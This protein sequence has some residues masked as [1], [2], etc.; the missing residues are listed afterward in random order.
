MTDNFADFPL[1]V[2]IRVTQNGNAPLAPYPFAAFGSFRTSH[3]SGCA[4]ISL[5]SKSQ[6]SSM[7]C[8]NQNLFGQKKQ[9]I[10]LSH[11]A[12]ILVKECQFTRSDNESDESMHLLVLP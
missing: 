3:A 1:A 12:T 6:E 8:S 10:A 4:S 5:S 9:L 7:T 11:S 2:A